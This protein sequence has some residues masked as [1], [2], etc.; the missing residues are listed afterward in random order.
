MG[1]DT[2]WGRE[3]KRAWAYLEEQRGL[4]EKTIIDANLGYIPGDY[5]EWREFEG[6]RVPCGI[7]IPWYAD[8]AIWG[9]KV[10]RAAGDLRYQ[11]VNGGNIKGCLYLTDHIKPG[12]PVLLTEGE[13]DALISWQVGRGFVCPASIGSAANGH[14]DP[15]WYRKLLAAPRILARMDAD[16]AGERA[17][18]AIEALSGAVRRVQVPMGKD[19]NDYYLA[20]GEDALWDWLTASLEP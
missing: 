20:A 5:Q 8:G 4:E 17:A 10:R 11:Q 6:L 2:L 18:A 13:F 3:G 1:M 7:T 12:L 9:I 15:R 14:I 16:P 19:I